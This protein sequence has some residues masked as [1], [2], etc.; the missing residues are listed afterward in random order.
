MRLHRVLTAACTLAL[1]GAAPAAA[2]EIEV[3]AHRGGTLHRGV[4]V[5]PENSMTAFRRAHGVDVHKIEVD[6]KLTAD[7][8]P[9][10]MHDATLDR[11]TNCSGLVRERT[12]AEL[13]PCRIDIIGTTGNFR[14]VGPREPIPT[15]EDFLAWARENGA[16]VNLEI[17]NLPTD[18]DF[19]RTG[20]FAR[21]VVQ[22]AQAAGLPAD[23]IMLQTFWPPDLEVAREA[24]FR[25]S[26]LTL[27][28]FNES[29]LA[30]ASLYDHEMVGPEWQ[31]VEPGYVTAAQAVGR[32]VITWTLN[33]EAALD[34]AV[35]AGVDGVISD[36]PA[37][38]LEAVQEAP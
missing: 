28:P 26:L 30:Y 20:A 11:T 21:T 8:V 14:Q 37:L 13:A 7:G 36:D 33:S 2:A 24:G 38:A 34:E 16:G 32:R 22:A 17:K 29:A 6:A 9:V 35:A 3:H 15:L 27:R 1:L 5:T 18:P 10:I 23:Q 19:D 12:L 25:T 31:L 4:A